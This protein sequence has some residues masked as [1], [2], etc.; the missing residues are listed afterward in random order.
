MVSDERKRD[1]ALTLC[2]IM[3]KNKYLT[4][5]ASVLALMSIGIPRVLAE[6]PVATVALEDSKSAEIKYNVDQVYEWNIH[7]GIDFGKNKGVNQSVSVKSN[8]VSVTKNVLEE[9]NKLVIEVKG[10]G[11]VMDSLSLMVARKN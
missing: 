2:N 7:S 3:R 9:G 1:I 11:D 6:E 5:S 4:I 10:S 8:V